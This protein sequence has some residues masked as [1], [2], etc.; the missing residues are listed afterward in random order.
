MPSSESIR[1]TGVV[2]C[3]I[4]GAFVEFEF[5]PGDRVRELRAKVSALWGMPDRSYTGH[6]LGSLEDMHRERD[7]GILSRYYMW[8]TKHWS[9]F[10]EDEA[11][12][13]VRLRDDDSL[14]TTPP[15]AFHTRHPFLNSVDLKSP[16]DMIGLIHEIDERDEEDPEHVVFG[17]RSESQFVPSCKPH[18]RFL[19]LY[20]VSGG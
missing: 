1:F 9:I 8:P 4:R 20:A 2:E 7:Q 13:F 10:V 19:A 17:W 16:K 12:A 14:P 15:A 5:E 11:G 3:P 18:V 6:P